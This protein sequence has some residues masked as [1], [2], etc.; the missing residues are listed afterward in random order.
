MA[1]K[2]LR[3]K[4]RDL[5]LR[6]IDLAKYMEI[7]RPS[8]Y[9]YIEM[10]EQGHKEA[11]APKAL[12]VFDYIEKSGAGKTDVIKFVVNHVAKEEGGNL[13]EEE[14]TR[15]AARSLLK[16]QSKEKEDFICALVADDF[17]DPVLG[18]LLE[19]RKIA[20]SLVV[21]DEEYERIKPLDNLYAA[22]GCKMRFLRR[23][24]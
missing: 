21:S 8:L 19:C 15:L 9:K 16:S 3:E 5:D 18:Y 6:I 7:S 13:S 12:A 2:F 22:L 23:R 14:R 11:I 24:V 1:A 4:M 17:F 10:Y 20:G